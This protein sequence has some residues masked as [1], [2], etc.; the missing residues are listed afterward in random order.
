[1]TAVTV[2]IWHNVAR[3]SQGNPT[4][5]LGGY[6]PA[7][8]MVRVF[9]YQAPL[10]GSPQEIAEEAFAIC[11]D[12]PRDADGADLAR[13]YYQRGLRSL[14]KGDVVAVGEAGL[15]VASVGW[16]P[17]CGGLNEVRASEHGTRPLPACRRLPDN[18]D[19]TVI[20]WPDQGAT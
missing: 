18:A 15:A 9:T 4:G 2:T 19:R 8:P 13:S 6:Q 16:T 3:D 17:V 1:M 14:S 12:H 10:A 5:M 20:P 11:N 7:D